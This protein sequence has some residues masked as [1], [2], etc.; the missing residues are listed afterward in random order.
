MA[1]AACSVPHSTTDSTMHPS[2]AQKREK[3]RVCC[4]LLIAVQTVQEVR[5]AEGQVHGTFLAPDPG[6]RLVRET[7]PQAPFFP[8]LSLRRSNAALPSLGR[9]PG[10]A[11]KLET[12]LA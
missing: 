4:G 1:P 3:R 10:V 8:L 2:R 7:E 6:L 12:R 5:M 11:S 9:R